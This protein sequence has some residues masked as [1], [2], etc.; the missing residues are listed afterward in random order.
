MD[1][2]WKYLLGYLEEEQITLD[3][4]VLKLNGGFDG[5]SKEV[6]RE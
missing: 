1:G 4:L 5:K 6:K 2:S 3:D